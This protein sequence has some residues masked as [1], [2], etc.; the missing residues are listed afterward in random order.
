MEGVAPE[1]GDREAVLAKR[2]LADEAA[3]VLFGKSAHLRE[4]LLLFVRL[5]AVVAFVVVPPAEEAF[6]DVEL[7]E[8]HG[9]L[10]ERGVV[11]HRRRFHGSAEV[12]FHYAGIE[13]PSAVIVD[14]EEL[15]HPVGETP[16]LLAEREVE[17]EADDDDVVVLALRKMLTDRDV[18]FEFREE[19]H[20]ASAS[21]SDRHVGRSEP[22]ER[23][24][25]DLLGCA[26]AVHELGDLLRD[27]PMVGGPDLHLIPRE[28]DPRGRVAHA[29]A[30]LHR[31]RRRV[32]IRD[33]VPFIEF[34]V[35]DDEAVPDERGAGAAAKVVRG[36]AV[37]FAEGEGNRPDVLKRL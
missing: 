23:R 14:R 3:Q 19:V 11:P 16:E 26:L 35:A 13:R 25:D 1:R 24:G 31:D 20:L 5:A 9:L 32:G 12:V 2:V 36:D 28:D 7:R 10:F 29:F 22:E 18:G 21:S 30:V 6:V 34:A 8:L 37:F 15:S 27:V 33:H 4:I 17:D